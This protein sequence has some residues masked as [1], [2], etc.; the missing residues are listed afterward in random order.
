MTRFRYFTAATLDGFLADDDDNLDW[1]MS[2]PIDEAGPLNYSE[3]IADVGALVMGATTYQW[4]VEHNATSGESWQYTQPAWVFT[5]RALEPVTDNVT[6]VAG[7]PSDFRQTLVEAAAG[8]DVWIVGGGDVAAQFAA[9]EMLDDVLISIAPVT[10]G[11]GRPLFT[12]A[13]DFQLREVDRNGPFIVARYDVVG[14]R[15]SV[16]D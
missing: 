11:S 7:S 5:H 9:A 6:I 2:Q 10:L 15:G 4:V 14:A 12:R 16:R 8:K 3:F 13:Y 1:L